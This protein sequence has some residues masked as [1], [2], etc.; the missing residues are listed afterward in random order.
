MFKDT[1]AF[2]GFSVDD[3][4]KAREFYEGTLG[5]EVSESN[6]MLQLHIAGGNPVLVYPKDNHTPASFTI[7]NF[8]VDNVDSAVDE[9]T[10]Q[11]VRFEHYDYPDMKT[12]EK[13]IMRGWGPAIAW[14]TDPAGNIMSV[15]EA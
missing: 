5:L 13:G 10:A 4:G 9:L 8:P 14:F 11:G 7:L 15:L 6:G 12:D 3:I 2:S 1:K